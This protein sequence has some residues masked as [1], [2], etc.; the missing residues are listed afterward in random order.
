[1]P[2]L[3]ILPKLVIPLLLAACD[4]P[5]TISTLPSHL[6]EAPTQVQV[7]EH[8]LIMETY[9]GRDFMPISPPD[10]KPM[11]AVLRI[12]TVDGQPFPSGVTAERVS[13][14]QGDQVWT[15]PTIKEHDSQEPHTLEVIAREGPKWQPG[16]KVDVVVY[17]RD[18]AGREHLLR[19][20]D[21]TIQRSD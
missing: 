9:V 7:E 17:L 8:S 14:V 21:Q 13:V 15:A 6:R 10:G 11:V 2:G 4:Q 20:P 18:S 19:A 1:M 5:T 3:R 16:T 12:R